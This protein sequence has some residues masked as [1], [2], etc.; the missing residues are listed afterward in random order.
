MRQC[1][2]QLSARPRSEPSGRRGHI[3][4]I[5]ESFCPPATVWGREPPVSPPNPFLLSRGRVVVSS[6]LARGHC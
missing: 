6:P 1:I 2:G 4:K 5:V 3:L